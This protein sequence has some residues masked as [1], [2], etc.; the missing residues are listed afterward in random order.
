MVINKITRGGRQPSSGGRVFRGNL[1]TSRKRRSFDLNETT[2]KRIVFRKSAMR[3]N[4]NSKR[5]G[6]VMIWRYSDFGSVNGRRTSLTDLA[7]T[8]NLTIIISKADF[9]IGKQPQS[10]CTR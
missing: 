10:K 7:L 4:R 2:L 5:L 3:S 1:S 6:G 9:L 8:L